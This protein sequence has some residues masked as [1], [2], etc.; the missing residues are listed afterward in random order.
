MQDDYDAFSSHPKKLIAILCERRRSISL[1]KTNNP[2]GE[3]DQ[4]SRGANRIDAHVG[5]RIRLRRRSLGMNQTTVAKALDI[6]Y[7]QVQ[8]YETGANRVSASRLSAMAAFLRVPVS[9]FFGQ[10]RAPESASIDEVRPH[11][12]VDGGVPPITF[13][14]AER[15]ALI[16]AVR[17]VLDADRYP[18]APRLEP[19]RSA[20]AKLDPASVPEPFPERK[21]LPEAPGR[22]R[23]ERR[24]RR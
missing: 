8:K 12:S 5:K 11:T 10:H 16:A 20:L 6:T 18:R 24:A 14:D 7:Q 9:F 15:T 22:T 3:D 21:P 1:M 23:G 17:K 2:T 4:G 19:L 13:T